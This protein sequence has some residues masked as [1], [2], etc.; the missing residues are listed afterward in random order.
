MGKK[1]GR[2]KKRNKEKIGGDEGAKGETTPR[3]A[4]TSGA[5]IME[6]DDRFHS[7]AVT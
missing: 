4:P 7:P 5:D 2:G 3:D 1:K 6:S